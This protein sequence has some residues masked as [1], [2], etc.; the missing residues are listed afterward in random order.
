MNNYDIAI[1]TVL[2]LILLSILVG[3]IGLVIIIYRD[4]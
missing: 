2:I 1:F 3:V 4:L